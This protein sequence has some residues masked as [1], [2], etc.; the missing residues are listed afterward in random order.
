MDRKQHDSELLEDLLS[1]ERFI[2]W[3]KH[4]T[5]EGDRYW[6]NWSANDSSRQKLIREAKLIL[7]SF[8]FK[9]IKDVTDREESVWNKIEEGKYSARCQRIDDTAKV[10]SI[11]ARWRL[12]RIAAVAV[13][14]VIIGSLFVYL[15]YNTLFNSQPELI[16]V[17]TNN[18]EKKTVVL[19][20]GT[21][22]YMNSGSQLS[23]LSVFKKRRDVNLT[24]EAF[25]KV[26]KD[27]TK[28]FIVHSSGY[29]TQALGTSFNVKAYSD[30]ASVTVA[31]KTGKV[32]VNNEKNLE[33]NSVFLV[34]GEKLN[35]V[36][37]VVL[38]SQIIA[39]DLSWKDG[40]LVLNQAGFAEFVKKIERWYGVHVDVHGDPGEDWRVNGRFK[41][42]PLAVV[43]ESISFA[44]N[45]DYTVQG[46]QVKLFFK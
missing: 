9:E 3:V 39:D 25:F 34:P 38:K 30:E 15:N 42:K 29:T 45:I 28:P 41:N 18:G 13:V 14:L 43:L 46:D 44:E 5:E 35:I 10:I 8:R 27:K 7:T 6:N 17:V 33:W 21:E 24:G 19:P 12:T 16:S 4:P 23:Y 22:I 20:D 26:A 11:S 1:N 32:V 37:D 2:E 31:L 36:S 40:V